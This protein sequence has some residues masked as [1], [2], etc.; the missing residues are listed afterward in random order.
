MIGEG[1]R[2]RMNDEALSGSRSILIQFSLIGALVPLSFI[3][4][5][6]ISGR[7]ETDFATFWIAGK[8]ALA[9]NT[10]GAYDP[11]VSAAVTRSLL[12]FESI[13]FPYPPQSLFFFA[14]FALLPHVPALIA[15]NVA[16]AAL[17]VFAARP[18]VPKGYPLLLATL[19]PAALLNIFFGQTG[20][21]FGALWLFAFN[22]A[23]LAVALL[24]FKPHM[25]ILSVLTLRSCRVFALACAALAGLI[26]LSIVAFGLETWRAFIDHGIRHVT[27]MEADI[28]EIAQ[29]TRW[30]FLGASP[31]IAYGF[32][33]WIPFAI[34]AALMLAR[35]FNVF[36]AATAGILISPYGFYYDL[37]VVTLGCSIAIFLQWD[38]LPTWRRLALALGFLSPIV[39]MAGAWWVPPVL[40]F[41]LWAQVTQPRADDAL[42]PHRDSAGAAL[43][44][45]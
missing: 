23:W 21:L 9:G 36:T 26:L 12:G 40:L 3:I 31:A 10:A 44:S 42:R 14:P 35:N 16:T 45:E 8:M 22:G 18:Y 32:V 15:W 37:T 29:R 28:G 27:E 33:G 20:L 41:T 5:T 39:A 24:A 13:N 2:Q 4:E 11:V 25:G 43:R 19:T 6:L 7:T 1:A 38:A 17:F 34:A 30:L